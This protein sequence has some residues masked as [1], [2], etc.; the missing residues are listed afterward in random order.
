MT[1]VIIDKNAEML[2]EDRMLQLSDLEPV[3]VAALESGVY[4]TDTKTGQF[5]AHQKIDTATFWVWFSATD[6]AYIIHNAY[7]HYVEV[8]EDE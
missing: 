5:I 1:K 7:S 8:I 6:T 2:C 4:L 3:V